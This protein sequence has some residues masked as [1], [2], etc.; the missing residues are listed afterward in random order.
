M[1]IGKQLR[2]HSRPDAI[3]ANQEI[4]FGVTAIVE[5][6]HHRAAGLLEA[7]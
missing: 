5:M 7:F 1:K 3:S 4:R 2:A 6:S